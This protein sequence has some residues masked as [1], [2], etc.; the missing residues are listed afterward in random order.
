MS[1]PITIVGNLASDPE[2]RFTATGKAVCTITIMTSRSVKGDDGKWTSEDVTAWN[3]TCWDELAE[4]VADSLLKGDP[5]VVVGTAASKSW[6]D[7][8]S[9]EKRS[10]LEVTA[11]EV[12]LSLK[13]FRVTAQ[14]IQR[15]AADDP[16]TEKVNTVTSAL[17][18][19][20]LAEEVPF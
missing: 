18:G 10:R 19:Q 13:R 3:T 12:A 9:G 2:L 15:S 1:Q 4:H 5:V 8:A 16:W 14:R 7:K 11:R 17:G 20:V 6:E